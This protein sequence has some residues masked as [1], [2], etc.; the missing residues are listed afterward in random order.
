MKFILFFFNLKFHSFR[1][2]PTPFVFFISVMIR[3]CSILFHS[4]VLLIWYRHQIFKMFCKHLFV[5]TWYSN[6]SF[7]IQRFTNY[8][9]WAYTIIIIFCPLEGRDKKGKVR[10]KE[11][12]KSCLTQILNQT[13]IKIACAS[14]GTVL[15]HGST[16]V[17]LCVLSSLCHHIFTA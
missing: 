12:D 9:E 2:I 7:H 8:I 15:A 14:T 13:P 4:S 16:M 17:P 11:D 1:D 10:E 6:L 3:F 5:R